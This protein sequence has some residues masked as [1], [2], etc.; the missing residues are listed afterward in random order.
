MFFQ[1]LG[2][3][4]RFLDVLP[5]SWMFFQ[6]LGCSSRFLD[7]L[8][9]MFFQVLGCSSRFLDVFPGS[10]SRL[11]EDYL[12]IFYTIQIKLKIESSNV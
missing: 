2:C 7:V 1:V 8:S 4:S 9:W 10:W 3:F 6:V 11:L 5:G 12:L